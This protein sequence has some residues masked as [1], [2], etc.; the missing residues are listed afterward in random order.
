MSESHYIPVELAFQ[1]IVD[2]VP[3]ALLVVNSD[4]KIAYVNF[5]A[6]KLFHYNPNELV[7]KDVTILIPERF[8]CTHK[9]FVK[10]FLSSPQV[11]PIGTGGELH[12]VKKDGEEMLIEVGLNPIKA[13]GKLMILISILDITERKLK[14]TLIKRQIALESKSKELEQFAFITS[15]DLREPL[16]TVANYIDLLEEDHI[17]KTDLTAHQY[18]NTMSKAIK[19]MESLIE[20]L[21]EYSNIGRKG[22]SMPVNLGEMILKIK[23][24]LL[25]NI[26]DIRI[27]VLI[28]DVPVIRVYETEIFRLFQFFILNAIKFRKKEI[29][30]EII[31][32]GQR[33]E[34]E[35]KF[36]VSDNGI[37]IHPKNFDKIFKIFQRL[38]TREQYEGNGMGLANC[39]KIVDLH[40]GEIWV[41]S[42]L[43]EGSTFYFTIP[44]E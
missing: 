5:F 24:N 2:A 14:E 22:E 13:D 37:G 31:I 6:E 12:A 15:H 41:E 27:I 28:E 7:G 26:T 40:R 1:S 44:D 36:S 4:N 34:T 16:R 8:R 9:E 25:F 43:G 11:R 39:K 17:E 42:A 23:D 32:R 10:I 35:W 18:I 3:N 33:L 19:K 29:T 30:P 21:L 20:S 38:H